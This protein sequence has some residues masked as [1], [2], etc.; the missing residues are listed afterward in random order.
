M[1]HTLRNKFMVGSN[2]YQIK[3]FSRPSHLLIFS[4]T[5]ETMET[6]SNKFILPLSTPETSV[7]IS[8]LDLLGD[9]ASSRQLKSL[10]E[11]E[12]RFFVKCSNY[13]SVALGKVG[14]QLTTADGVISLGKVAG[15]TPQTLLT[16]DELKDLMTSLEKNIDHTEAYNYTSMV[17]SIMKGAVAY[18]SA[19]EPELEDSFKQ[20][21]WEP[22]VISGEEFL[23][24]FETGFGTGGLQVRCAPAINNLSP[25]EHV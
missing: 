24:H 19:L 4:L 7:I 2:P 17:D 22:N 23:C 10:C 8:L 12:K 16:S 21:I 18:F 25:Y 9:G 3:H 14:L 5:A 15:S 20:V 13:I 1:M 6:T 11:I